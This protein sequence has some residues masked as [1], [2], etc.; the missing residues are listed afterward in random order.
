V[1]YGIGEKQ[2][3]TDTFVQMI[4]QFEFDQ[5]TDAKHPKNTSICGDRTATEPAQ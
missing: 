1:Q 2:P 3:Y 4:H 5:N